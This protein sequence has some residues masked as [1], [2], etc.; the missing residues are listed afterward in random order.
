MTGNL[1]TGGV[2]DEDAPG[3][4]EK[5]LTHKMKEI[6]AGGFLHGRSSGIVSPPAR[7]TVSNAVVTSANLFSNLL[8]LAVRGSSAIELRTYIVRNREIK[9]AWICCSIKHNF[10]HIPQNNIL[11]LL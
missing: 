4:V 9:S 6:E 8:R 10:I 1:M 7:R 5:A 3:E 2:N 11:H